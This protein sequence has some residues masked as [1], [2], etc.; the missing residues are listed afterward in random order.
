VTE[1][2]S[3]YDDQVTN[4][5]GAR[6]SRD[7]ILDQAQ[8]LVS[9]QGYDGMA[10]SEL[11]ALSGLPPSSIYY[12]FGNKLGVLTAL[13]ER[14]FTDFHKYSPDPTSFDDRPPVERFELWFTAVCDSLDRRPE[15]L[16]LLLAVVLGSHSSADTVQAVVRRI[17]DYAHKSWVEALSPIF[18]P[19]GSPE[20]AE[21]LQRMAV[22]GRAVTDGLSVSTTVDG[23]SYGSHVA[24]FVSL[25]R[26]FAEQRERDGATL[27]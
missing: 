17:R 5:T 15:Y 3:N 4:E 10:I 18:D 24:P 6:S 13:L 11:S 22:L 2:R 27:P 20:D 12:H 8:R 9:T 26:A 16:R 7:V 14:A 23:T 19:T 21:L 25:V 1:A